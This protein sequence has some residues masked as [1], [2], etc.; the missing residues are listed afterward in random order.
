[1][2]SDPAGEEFMRIFKQLYPEV[3]FVDVTQKR[4]VKENLTVEG[5]AKEVEKEKKGV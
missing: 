4:T 5:L 3:E 1:L 2:M